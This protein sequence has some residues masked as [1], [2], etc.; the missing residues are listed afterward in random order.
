MASS[1]TSDPEA[2]FELLERIGK[3]YVDFSVEHTFNTHVE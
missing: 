1:A 3:G 2:E